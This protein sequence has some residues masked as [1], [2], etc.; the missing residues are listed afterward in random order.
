MA[1]TIAYM[2]T[3]TTYGTWL[4]GNKRP[5]VKDGRILEANEPLADANKEALEKDPVRFN[6]EHRRIVEEAIR[7]KAVQFNQQVY[8]LAVCYDHVH[9]LVAYVPKPI[10]FVVQHYKAVGLIALRKIGIYGKI[11]TK[12]FNKRYCF[13]EVTL[14]KKIEY[15]NRHFLPKNI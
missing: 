13:D 3:W 9:L 6:K 11:W 14:Q 4:Q 8:A 1:K 5:Y 15:V 7:Q 12:G 10:D 2:V